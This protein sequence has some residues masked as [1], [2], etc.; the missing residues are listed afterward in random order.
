MKWNSVKV[1]VTGAGGFIGSHLVERLVELGATTTAFVR[2]TSR[3]DLGHLDDAPQE[4]RAATRILQ[5]DIRDEAAV[6]NAIRGQDIV[7]H[8]AA[9]ISIPYSYVNPAEVA[10]TNV[11][12]TLNVL[13]ACRD[14]NVSRLVHTSTSEVYGTAQYV[15]IDERHPLKGQS[16]Y[17]AS[18][19][20]A[21]KLVESFQCA[22]GV[23]AVTLRPFNTYGPRQSARA[24]IPTIITQALTRG[25]V[26]LGALTP[27]RDLTFVTDT[28]EA[29]V[30][31][32]G[33]P[34]VV[35]ET[36]NL[37]SGSEVTI[38]DLA[39]KLISLTGRNARIVF[40]SQRVRPKD[41]E[42]ERLL[43]DNGKAK[44]LLGWSP[45]MGLDGGLSR[46]VDWIAGNLDQYAP[47]RY[48]V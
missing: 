4:I 12:G 27:T 6:R 9:S 44:T 3:R 19:I 11:L 2:Y 39:A 46:T 45:R 33:A 21:D 41:S 28:A 36:I 22:F 16:P 42:V 35:G 47:T 34:G 32:A 29:F 5:G 48:M 25:E 8:L 10:A 1:I 43:S 20:G 40:D 13:Q 24:V 31:A 15:P 38:G 23:P 14:E 37:G 17:S 26:H 18:K 7:M 30:Q